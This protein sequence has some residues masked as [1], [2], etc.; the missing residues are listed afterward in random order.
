M[1]QVFEECR[2]LCLGLASRGVDWRQQ[3]LRGTLAIC[4]GMGSKLFINLMARCD[5]IAV[6]MAARGFRGPQQHVLYPAGAS[7][8]A[9]APAA[10]P[11]GLQLPSAAD[12]GILACLALLF[13]ASCTVI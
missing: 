12:V 7:E 3:G 2:N 5:N 1:L 11:R 8:A 10:V 9:E 4:V 6:A 13:A